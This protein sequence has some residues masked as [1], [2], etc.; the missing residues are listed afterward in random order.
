MDRRGNKYCQGKGMYSINH[1]ISRAM[2]G[3]RYTKG[4]KEDVCVKKKTYGKLSIVMKCPY[5]LI[6]LIKKVHR[7]KCP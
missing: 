1:K 6:G 7:V 4:S 2:I 5:Y 3:T